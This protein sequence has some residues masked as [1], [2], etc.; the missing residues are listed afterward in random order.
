[1]DNLQKYLKDYRERAVF[2]EEVLAQIDSGLSERQLLKLL[3]DEMEILKPMV[4]GILT[5]KNKV[6]GLYKSAEFE[7]CHQLYERMKVEIKRLKK[8]LSKVD[9]F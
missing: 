4:W 9:D 8:A 3:M 6:N 5:S 2:T 7:K 1:M